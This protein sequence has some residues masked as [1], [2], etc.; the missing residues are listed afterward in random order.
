MTPGSASSPLHDLLQDLPD[1]VFSLDAGGRLT[2][3]NARTCAYF[4][5]SAE[6]LTGQV[7]WHLQ[8]ELHGSAAMQAVQDALQTG[9]P[10]RSELY[11]ARLD[12]WY[13][14]RLFP[15]GQTGGVQGSGVREPGIQMPGGQMPGVHQLGVQ[16]SDISG[17]KRALNALNAANAS[18]EGRVTDRTGELETSRIG[19]ELLAAL[20][21]TLQQATSAEGVSELALATIGPALKALSMLVVGLD[22][23]HIRLPTLWGD[24]PGPIMSHMTRPGLL[25]TET[26]L[27]LRV[28][29]QQG[30]LYGE[31]YSREFGAIP[32]F[33]GLAFGAEPIRTPGGH[34]EGVLVVW[35]EPG[36]TSWQDQEREL[37][38]RAAATLGLALE[39]ATAVAQLEARTRQ[40]EATAKAQAAFVAFTEAVGSETEVPA[41]ARRAVDVLSIHFPGCS[42]TYHELEEDLWKARVY[43]RDLV[44]NPA[45]LSL[46]LA[47]LPP[48]TP[49]FAAAAVQ[50]APV[51]V[52]GW[53]AQREAI[54][55]TDTYT[56]AAA[57]PLVQAGEARAVLTIGLQTQ[58]AWSESDR[59]VFRSVGRGLALALE[60]SEQSARLAAQNAELA[61]Q[62]RAL[63]AFSDL[64]GD[65]ALQSDP[66][67]LIMRAQ[68]VVLSML[69]TGAALYYELEGDLWRLKVQVGDLG[70]P[71]LQA[72]I[73]R[74]LPYEATLNLLIPYRSKQSYFQEVYDFDTDQL[75]N[76]VQNIGATAALPVLVRGEVRGIL[77][78]ALFNQRQWTAVDRAVLTSVVRSL[79]LAV[80]G[81]LVL[82]ELNRTQHYL[83]VAADHAPI[84]L[85]AT[86]A[87]G[88]FTLSE[89][90][91]LARMG[92]R[93]GEAVGQSATAMFSNEADLKEGLRLERALA[94]ESVHELTRF[95]TMGLVLET[96]FVPICN[97]VGEVT[98]VVGVSIDV[99]DR[100]EVQRRV[101]VAYAGLARS[102]AELLVANDE[103]EAFAY[104]ASHDLRTPVRH[105]KGFSELARMALTRGQPD[106]AVQHILVVES[107]AD[108]MSTLIDAMLNLSRSTSQEL[109]RGAVDL[110]VL[111]DRARTDAEPDVE[112]RSFRWQ[113]SPLPVVTGDASTLQQVMTNLVANAVKFSR[114]RDVA[115]LQVWAEERPAEWVIHV[116]DNGVG[117]DSDYKDK[118]FGVFKRLHSEREFEGTG[119]GLATVRRI[120]LRHG[121]QV[122]AESV[123]GEGATFSFTLPNKG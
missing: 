44:A 77:V 85:F 84:L 97:L 103:L 93:P 106:K 65:F 42:S 118:L 69:P 22:G 54:E 83:Q 17:R 64:T 105:V 108:R 15:L 31:D 53:D 2:W 82:R 59:A 47:G 35:R 37:L 101:E 20:G 57:Y 75:Q 46:L 16:L 102:N 113:I 98:E 109:S 19:A 89:G 55:Q 48:Q 80:E 13:E 78:V 94:G 116:R 110:N 14:V 45:L 119:V 90:S 70:A 5:R 79:G 60:R 41:L 29:K 32:G 63:E 36:Q 71:E 72:A 21:D 68:E 61:A 74:G 52:D 87:E 122:S 34:L 1:P 86:D 66:L 115:V 8:P 56:T 58:K 107:A 50:L 81:A 26:P 18:L 114:T 43:S 4:G 111:L 117:F 23:E 33:P 123:L 30:G 76:L 10:S 6:A 96:W 95:E 7:W 112:G 62:T 67:A 25:L 39:R 92:L 88:V 49:L 27:L 28:T 12:C 120:V 104:S 24:T 121:G 100:L 40:I 73:D 99:T 51:F 3:A 38:R 11:D 91:L 9:A